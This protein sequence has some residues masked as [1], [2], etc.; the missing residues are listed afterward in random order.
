[1]ALK[2]PLCPAAAKSA[3]SLLQNHDGGVLAT[4]TYRLLVGHWLWGYVA[5]ALTAA[6]IFLMITL[7]RAR[8]SKQ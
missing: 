3:R 4:V 2:A 5:G 6:A 8:L 7:V 1:M